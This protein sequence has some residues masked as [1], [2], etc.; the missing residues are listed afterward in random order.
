MNKK[1]II[2]IFIIIILIILII[3]I[4][5]NYK[6]ITVGNN[7]NKSTQS[8]IEYI[9]NISSYE[10]KI[11][12]TINSNKTT[13]QYELTQ[14]YFSPNIY[15][16]IVNKPDYINGL[17][18][19]YDGNNLILENTNLSMTKVYEKYE[20][21]NNNCLWLDSFIENYKTI[22]NTSFEENESEII[23]EVR[24]N[25]NLYTNIKRLYIDKKQLKPIKLEI[26][27]NNKNIKIYIIY[28]EIELNSTN[29][30]E[31]LAFKSEENKV[32]L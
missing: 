32:E 11:D 1:I 23:L 31:I 16:Q 4:K 17:T 10:A 9:L 21:L 7:I 14:K 29:K 15:K 5:N 28:R 12:V 19:K 30:D 2:S 25:N 20:C 24:D 27:D 13:N 8:V 6:K 3:F 18:M 22:E 26:I